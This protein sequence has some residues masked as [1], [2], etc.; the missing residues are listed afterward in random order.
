MSTTFVLN[1]ALSYGSLTALLLHTALFHFHELVDKFHTSSD[2]EDDVHVRIY[3]RYP[4]VPDWWYITLFLI[5]MG[6]S[7]FVCEAWDTRLPFLGFLVT[8]LIP[9][10]FILPIGIVRAVTNVTIGKLVLKP[11]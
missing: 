3:K 10:I 7:I 9:F 6:L 8:Q 2:R 11:C 1:Y 4:E 5:M